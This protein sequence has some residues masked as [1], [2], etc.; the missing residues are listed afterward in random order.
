MGAGAERRTHGVDSGQGENSG[1]GEDS[2]RGA[3]SSA[4]PQRAVEGTVPRPESHEHD[5][6]AAGAPADI[7]VHEQGEATG[8]RE[9]QGQG[10]GAGTGMAEVPIADPGPPHPSASSRRPADGEEEGARRGEDGR[11]SLEQEVSELEKVSCPFLRCPSQGPMGLRPLPSM[12]QPRAHRTK[13]PFGHEGHPDTGCWR[14][15]VHHRT[16]VP[17][18]AVP[19]SPGL[20]PCS[21]SALPPPHSPSCFPNPSLPTLSP[22]VCHGRRR[23]WSWGAG[24]CWPAWQRRTG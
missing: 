23:C 3:E 15:T 17:L 9:G 7:E 5:A 21:S 6:G 18:T 4:F 16:V 8:G 1:H 10:E 20:L 19:C 11:P 22:L 14:R 13:A 2:G 12:P 24:C